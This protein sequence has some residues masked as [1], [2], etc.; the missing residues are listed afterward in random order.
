MAHIRRAVSSDGPALA[1]LRWNFRAEEGETP[2]D[3]FREFLPRYL[4]HYWRG[5]DAGT[6]AHWLVEED[7]AVLAHM[8]VQLQEGV[9]HPATARNRWGWLTDCYTIPEA[10]NQGH[11]TRLLSA[12][13]E[14]AAS[15]QLELLLVSPS[16]GSVPFYT[17]LGFG[18]AGE[19][20]Q[21]GLK[22][23]RDATE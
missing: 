16:D 20:L 21:L 9:P 13:R 17:R 2:R 23:P 19:W 22:P 12:I 4:E 15:E 7:R 14:W 1:R 10:R 6:W 18:P 8:A 3:D 11:G 5:L